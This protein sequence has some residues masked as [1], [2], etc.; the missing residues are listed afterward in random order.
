[1]KRPRKKGE[2]AAGCLL[3]DTIKLLRNIPA[4]ETVLRLR[5]MEIL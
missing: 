1:M 4:D 3:H 2:S 5:P